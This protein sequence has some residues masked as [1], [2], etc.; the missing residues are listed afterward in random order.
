MNKYSSNP[1][2]AHERRSPCRWGFRLT[3][4]STIIFLT[5]CTRARRPI[6]ATEPVHQELRRLW[7]DA[8]HWRVGKYVIMPDHSHL[9]VTVGSACTV[10]LPRWV[11]WWK[12]QLALALGIKVWQKDFWDHMVR[13]QEAF[14]QA[15]EYMLLN[16]SRKGLIE[17]S[18]EWPFQ[19]E[20]HKLSW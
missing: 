17:R 6:L 4:N 7:S 11:G 9:L 2:A 5:V 12:R 18:A 15:Q 10:P 13:G 20:V 19:G 16:P 1:L 14:F 3:P 8:T